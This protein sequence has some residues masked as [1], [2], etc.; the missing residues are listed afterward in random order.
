MSERNIRFC[1]FC[2][3]DLTTGDGRTCPHCGELLRKDANKKPVWP[4][5]FLLNCVVALVAVW[6]T[7]SWVIAWSITLMMAAGWWVIFNMADHARNFMIQLV[8]YQELERR[9]TT[10]EKEHEKQLQTL[11]EMAVQQ[12]VLRNAFLQLPMST[13]AS[14]GEELV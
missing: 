3:A 11:R 6:L 10:I 5:L 13:D 12:E 1:P 9:I 7:S 2:G 8:L 4:T 14:E